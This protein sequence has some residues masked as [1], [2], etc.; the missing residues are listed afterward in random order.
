MFIVYYK[1]DRQPANIGCLLFNKGSERHM[2]EFQLITGIAQIVAGVILVVLYVLSRVPKETIAQQGELIKALTQRQQELLDAHVLNE[3]AISE[4][5]GQIKVY[6]ELPLQQI[7]NSLKILETLPAE[8]ERISHESK[9]AIISSVQNINKQHVGT[10]L[11]D[12]RKDIPETS[13]N[14]RLSPA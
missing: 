7:A 3:K 8:F 12:H 9:E 10:Q 14:L 6:K 13:K 5:Q 2:P 1:A 4:L 11:V